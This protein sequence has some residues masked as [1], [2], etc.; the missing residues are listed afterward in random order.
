MQEH[1]F[2]SVIVPTY[3]RPGQLGACLRALARL[4]YARDRF[5]VF[6]VDD[7]SK[8]SPESIVTSFRDRLDVALLLQTHAGPA[9]ARNRGAARARG[10]FLAFTDDDCMPA[11][12]WL[13]AMAARFEKDSDRLIGGR[14]L[15]IISDN[16]YSIASQA[17]VDVVY[18]YYNTNPD[19]AQFFASNNLACSSDRFRQLGGFD[20]TFRT[21]ED[22][23]F[24][25]RWLHNHHHMTYAPEAIVYH[26]HNLTLPAFWRQHFSYGRGSFRF[27][28]VRS[29]RG[30]GGFR[31]DL[32]FYSRL[33]RYPLSGECQGRAL[34]LLSS[35]ML[36]QAASAAGFVWEGINQNHSSAQGNRPL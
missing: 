7:G 28:R 26:A 11:P 20:P 1:P 23:E 13:G 30:R 21:S 14:T 12:H 6:V 15:N 8:S 2:F 4:Q 31:P 29:G 3:N 9:A 5:E 36:S 33:L 24:C 22:R 35:L 16:P 10:R 32:T 19:E 25:D 18:A 27:H 17:V 34:R